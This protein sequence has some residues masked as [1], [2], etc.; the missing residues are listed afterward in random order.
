MFLSDQANPPPQDET[1][2]KL[3]VAIKTKDEY[4]L[5]MHLVKSNP[6]NYR[7]NVERPAY[8]EDMVKSKCV[9]EMRKAPVT[10]KYV[11]RCRVTP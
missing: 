7:P 8:H 3:K 1:S 11:H 5:V 4:G 10:I 6:Q 9:T 2:E